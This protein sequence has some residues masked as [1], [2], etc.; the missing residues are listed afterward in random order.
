[1]KF[2]KLGEFFLPYFAT[3]GVAQLLTFIEQLGTVLYRNH[4]V[5]DRQGLA[6]HETQ[7]ISESP[8]L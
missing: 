4:M 5:P 8:L 3:Q 1:M 2:Q 6:T 7:K